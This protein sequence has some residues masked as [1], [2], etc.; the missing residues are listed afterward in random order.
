MTNT[1]SANSPLV[2]HLTA[3]PARRCMPKAV[4]S[5]KCQT[6]RPPEAPTPERSPKPGGQRT[7]GRPPSLPPLTPEKARSNTACASG[8]GLGVNPP[9]SIGPS[10]APEPRRHEEPNRQ[11]AGRT[12]L[13]ECVGRVVLELW[14]SGSGRGLRGHGP[15]ADRFLTSRTAGAELRKHD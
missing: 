4:R 14:S 5:W 15:G 9:R 7:P 13:G 12:P 1:R 11:I 2:P 3:P 6:T 10:W 8:I